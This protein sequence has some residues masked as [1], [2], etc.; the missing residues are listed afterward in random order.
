MAKNVLAILNLRL[1]RWLDI[2]VPIPSAFSSLSSVDF[3]AEGRLRGVCVTSENQTLLHS[4]WQ[5]IGLRTDQNADE[6]ALV[7]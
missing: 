4:G 3:N 1:Q 5:I 6:F 7:T 2:V